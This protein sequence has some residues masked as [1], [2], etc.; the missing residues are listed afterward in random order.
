M[1]RLCTVVTH[2]SPWLE[3]HLISRTPSCNSHVVPEDAQCPRSSPLRG[4]PHGRWRQ[5]PAFS[6]CPPAPL[7]AC[8]LCVGVS[9]HW[10]AHERL[11]EKCRVCRNVTGGFAERAHRTYRVTLVTVRKERSGRWVSTLPGSPFE[12]PWPASHCRRRILL[13]GERRI[14]ICRFQHRV[15]TC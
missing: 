15:C 4:R 10:G 9:R 5:S 2:K 6:V 3:A 1:L 13:P 8:P 11:L 7:L 12:N 14:R